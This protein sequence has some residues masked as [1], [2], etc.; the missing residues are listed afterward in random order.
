ML[1]APPHLARLLKSPSSPVGPA[2]TAGHDGSLLD[3][4][5]EFEMTAVRM[6]AFGLGVLLCTAITEG[7]SSNASALAT[8]QTRAERSDFTETSGSSTTSIHTC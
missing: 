2:A 4:C 3:V 5:K 1:P 7:Q 8:L 6:L